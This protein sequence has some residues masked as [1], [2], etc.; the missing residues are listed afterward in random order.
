MKSIRWLLHFLAGLPFIWLG[1]ELIFNQ[2]QYFGADPVKELIH[3]LGWIAI[4]LFV[5]LFL[6]R[7]C[8]S[9]FKLNRLYPYHS[10]FGVWAIIWASFHII[11]YLYLELGLD[12]KLFLLELVE[13]PYLSLGAFAFVGFI[14]SALIMLP[15]IKRHIKAK[16]FIFHQVSYIALLLATL[17]YYWSIKGIQFD[18]FIYLTLVCIVIFFKLRKINTKKSI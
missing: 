6:F 4:T 7:L 1:Y 2:A 14:S 10:I 11:A 3:F 13:R 18:V 8:I 17:H 15:I 16:V 12:I 5:G 9:W